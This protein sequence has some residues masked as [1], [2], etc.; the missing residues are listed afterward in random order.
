MKHQTLHMIGN[1]H[2]DPV[3][4]WRWDEGM[5]EVHATFRAALDLMNAY[6][7]FVFTASSAAFYAWIE[8][9]DPPMFDEIQRR[10]AEGRWAIVGGW[11]I[12]P[13][14]NIPCGESFVR[15]A[16]Y[17]QRY[18]QEKFGIAARVGYCPDSFG[19]HATL[20]Q[21]LAQSGIAGYVVMRPGP[22]EKEL[23]GR[24]FWWESVDGSR[25]LAYR[26]PFAYET[27]GRDLEAHVR[28]CTEE[29]TQAQTELMCFYGVGNH[30]GGPTRENLE[31]IRRLNARAD[32][33]R[34]VFSSPPRF[35]ASVSP[36]PSLPVVRDELQHHARG[37]YA[38][39]S[40]VKHWNRQAENLL[41]TAEKFTVL[42]HW[43][44]GQS[45]SPE[46]ARAWKNVLF[47]Q[48]HD[49]LAGTS[50]PAAYGEARNTYGEAMEIAR[51]AL[52]RAVQS[53][54]WQIR[55]PAEDGMTPL[56]V[57]NPHAWQS[58]TCVEFEIET[59]GN[60]ILLNDAGQLVPTQMIQAWATVEWRRRFCFIAD[61]PPLGYRVYRVKPGAAHLQTSRRDISRA[62]HLEND[63]FRLEL[64]PTTGFVTRLR[65]KQNG[66]EVLAGAAARP[67]VIDDPSDT[68]GHGVARF[69]HV[70]GEFAARRITRIEDGPVR[71]TLHVESAYGASRLIQDFVMYSELD[72]IDV[73]VTVDWREQ[74]K[75]LKLRFPV[76]ID[77]ARATCE[78]PYGHVIRD[79]NGEEEPMQSWI[80]VSGIARD[81]RVPYGLSILNDGKYSIDV[82][83][84]DIGLTVL[85]S[86]I[87]A[88]HQPRVPQSD[89]HYAFIDQGIQ[90]FTYSLLPHAASWEQVGTVRRAAELNQPPVV[91]IE[92]YHPD[93]TLAQHDAY[94]VVDPENVIVSVVKQAEGNDDMIVRA[95][96]FAYVPTRATIRLPYWNR[97]IKTEFAPGEIKT[98]LIPKDQA[99]SVVETNL[100]EREK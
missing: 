96:E 1:A 54:A 50:I 73:R 33:P 30:G 100:L 40:A 82:R 37:C 51:R 52:Y 66:V 77:A 36:S 46:F 5:H 8:A 29:L 49:I 59:A 84:S 34:L 3:W 57:F 86:P 24:L 91:M 97:V 21:I 98:W 20:P 11:W 68:W 32:F 26:I 92:S 48:F 13:D 39:H 6:D 89:E 25:V 71:S 70:I 38:A 64:D 44:T 72:Q 94:L 88:H 31:S 99:Q 53:I 45:Y 87:Y 4:L 60:V 69:D 7:D 42:A 16:L 80:D 81:P 79:A 47:N 83:G 41:L 17:G 19:H 76:N 85:R 14:C 2:I 62:T 74:F 78:V 15:Q 61:L 18:F 90:H 27:G 22:D 9:N 35:F 23:P 93:G 55:I 10:V 43:L 28:L 12:E 95:Y 58:K 56:V 65:D 63:R 75:M 67:V